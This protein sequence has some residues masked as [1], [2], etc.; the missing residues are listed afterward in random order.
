MERVLSLEPGINKI[1]ERWRFECR[2]TGAS[3]PKYIVR[4][5]ALNPER[6]APRRQVGQL[7]TTLVL[8]MSRAEAQELADA[9]REVLEKAK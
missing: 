7:A 2:V 9:I 5:I 6:T 4:G 8:S 3:E 1:K